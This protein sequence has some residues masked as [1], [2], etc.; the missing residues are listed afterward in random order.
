MVINGDV[1]SYSLISSHLHLKDI[2]KNSSWCSHHCLY[3]KLKV[4]SFSLIVLNLFISS[5]QWIFFTHMYGQMRTVFECSQSNCL[6]PYFVCSVA[7][8]YF[9]FPFMLSCWYSMLYLST[10]F[11]D[12]PI[13]FLKLKQ[14]N[15]YTLGWLVGSSFGLF[16]WQRT[17][18]HFSPYAMVISFPIFLN[19]R[20]IFRLM[21]G[22]Q[23]NFA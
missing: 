14:S 23:S 11:F 16:F 2:F 1:I 3:S 7:P 6:W 19:S 20:F 5:A 9:H 18:C 12:L 4:L 15:R 8:G 17:C 21:F 10:F 22:I 13:Y